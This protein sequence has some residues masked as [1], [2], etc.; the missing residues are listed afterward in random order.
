MVT[1]EV[2]GLAEVA[3]IT[4]QIQLEMEVVM[5]KT[6]NQV[7]R[8]EE[9]MAAQWTWLHTSLKS[10]NSGQEKSKLPVNNEIETQSCSM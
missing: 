3:L 2:E 9:A 7:P 10:F 1:L 4:Q 8:V 6:E 5:E